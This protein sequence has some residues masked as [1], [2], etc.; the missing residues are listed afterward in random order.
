M[1]MAEASLKELYSI[2]FAD[3]S[4][5]TALY[6]KLGDTMAQAQ[7]GAHLEK[8]ATVVAAHHGKVI[9]TI[10]DELMCRFDDPAEAMQASCEIHKLMERQ[11]DVNGGV[12]LATRIGIHYGP[13][14]LKDNDL[15]GDAVNVAARVTSLAKP[16]Q[17][18]TTAT[19]VSALPSSKAIKTRRLDQTHLKGKQ[20]TLI[21][22]EVLWH[23]E[24]LTLLGTGY[25]PGA[26][27]A[28]RLV[29]RYG[30]TT[31]VIER[32]VS[33]FTIGRD[34]TCNLQLLS[35]L[36]SRLHGKIEHRV[37][38]FVFADHSAN[39]TYIRLPGIDDLFLRREELPLFGSGVIACGEKIKDDSPH[40]IHFSCE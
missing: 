34:A 3:I 14:I 38:K 23:Q 2:L 37:G 27:A 10:G 33:S 22:H 19:T 25:S 5:S 40:L 9:K 16:Q 18:L 13:A 30:D 39:G 17:T 24:N 15:F 32:G 1:T 35:S 7:I 36:A 6:E 29:L 31:R 20:E 8:I 4:G 11:T 21:L 26:G 12:P 28:E